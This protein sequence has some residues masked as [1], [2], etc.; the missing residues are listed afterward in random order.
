ML[1]SSYP[2]L[3][4]LVDEFGEGV[5]YPH[6][7][8]LTKSDNTMDT[9][10]PQP[11]QTPQS[12]TPIQRVSQG[13]FAMALIWSSPWLVLLTIYFTLNSWRPNLA[14]FSGA[15]PGFITLLGIALFTISFLAVYSLNAK[16]K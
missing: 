14:L 13:T 1:G 5:H 8:K 6:G 7:G 10:N 4:P 9:T 16:K 12:T 15:K 11:P 3:H 2:P